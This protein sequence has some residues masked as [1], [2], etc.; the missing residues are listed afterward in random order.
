MLIDQSHRSWFIGTLVALAIAVVVY[1]PYAQAVE[2]PSGGS[3][4]GIVYGS[5]GFACMLFA[6]LLGLRKKF[7]IWRIGRAQSWMRGHLWLGFLSF[8]IILMHG[9][10]HFG[11]T[12]TRVMMWMFVFIFIS[13]IFGA[14][15]QHYM[16][17]QHTANLP[18]ETIFEQIDHVRDQLEVEAGEIVEENCATLDGE[19]SHASEQQLAVAAAAG[20]HWDITVAGGLEADE[21]ASHHLRE[22]FEEEL[23]PYL[24]ASGGGKSPLA[25]ATTARDMFQQLRINLPDGM[26]EA[27]GD[28]ES[29]AEEKRQLDQQKR[30]HVLLHGWLL[31]HI[32]LSY[33]VLLLG[34]FH[35]VLA[36]KY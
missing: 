31:V 28:L 26:H 10:F 25:S 5:I 35:A 18:M 3:T 4:L 34:A 16:P 24:E 23:S 27:V 17:R 12:L 15:L 22:F 21:A 11:G 29:L 32:P 2:R 14:V 1:I 33:A 19:L 36:L 30:Y 7:P 8:P 13:G 6:G 20:T 9:A